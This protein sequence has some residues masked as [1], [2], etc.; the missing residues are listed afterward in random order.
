MKSTL[1]KS[2]KNRQ[3]NIV[4]TISSNYD[5][6]PDYRLFNFEDDKNINFYKAA[7]T[8]YSYE[9]FQMNKI[10]GFLNYLIDEN[11]GSKDYIKLVELILE[12]YFWDI[13]EEQRPGI[14]EYRNYTM[15][16]KYAQLLLS[17]SEELYQELELA[18]YAKKKSS[19]LKTTCKVIVS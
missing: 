6:L 17:P 12:E 15:N 16:K 18:Y 1:N 4:W 7:L 3:D 10:Y 19:E 14:V 2:N 5:F 13:Y 8:G 9:Y 11:L